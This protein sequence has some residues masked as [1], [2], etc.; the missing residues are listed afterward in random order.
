L[1]ISIIELVVG[2]VSAAGSAIAVAS[3][4]VV[5]WLVASV[6]WLSAGFLKLGSAMGGLISKA[7]NVTAQLWS[8]V[9]KPGLQHV[10]TWIKDARDWLKLKLKPAFDLL[11]KVRAH[12]TD[13]Y[14]NWIKPIRDG[15][16]TTSGILGLLAKLHV[17]FAAW[18]DSHVAAVKTAIDENFL[19]VLGWVNGILNTLNSIVTADLLF[20]RVP[21]LRTL[22]RDTPHWLVMWWNAQMNNLSPDHLTD[23]ARYPYPRMDPKELATNLGQFYLDGTGVLQPVIEELVPVYMGKLKTGM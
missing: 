12:I 16:D 11:A 19:R 22:S 2:A 1:F 14:K 13:I 21:F 8:D 4:A 17:P 7:W 10:W 9:I 23:Y 18:L 15:L 5:Q 3:V 6:A 20:Q